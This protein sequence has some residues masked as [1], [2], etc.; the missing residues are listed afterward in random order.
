[1]FS[2]LSPPTPALKELGSWNVCVL[3]PVV[4]NRSIMESPRRTTSSDLVC[5]SSGRCV[6][7]HVVCERSLN[8]AMVSSC[9]MSSG[10]SR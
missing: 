10:G 9:C 3:I 1:M 8:F 6:S 5:D 7:W 2:I 4:L